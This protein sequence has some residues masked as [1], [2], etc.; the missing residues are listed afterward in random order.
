MIKRNFRKISCLLVIAIFGFYGF[1]QNSF[2]K[3]VGTVSS[4]YGTSIIPMPNLGSLT[5]IGG[6]KNDGTGVQ[7]GLVKTNYNGAIEWQKLFVNGP[8][9]LAQNTVQ[10]SDGGLCVFG[11]VNQTMNSNKALFILKTDSLGNVLWSYRIQASSSDRAV[12]IIS[13]KSGGFLSCSI[14]GYNNGGYPS[15]QLI[16]Y[17]ESGIILWTKKYDATLGVSPKSVIELSNG[18][19]GF[20]SLINAGPPTFFGHTLLT[21]TDAIGNLRWSTMFNGEYQDEPFDLLESTSGEF[22]ITGARYELAKEWDGYYL[23]VDSAGNRISNTFYDANTSSGEYF[24]SMALTADNGI[25]LLGDAG[26]FDA[27]NI[28]LLKINQS[29]QVLWSRNYPFSS[30]Y[31][32]YGF[33]IYTS[34]DQGF[35]FSG[36]VRPQSYFR[37]AAIIKAGKDGVIP[38]FTQDL[39]FTLN[40]TPFNESRI[41]LSQVDNLQITQEVVVFTHP[42]DQITEKLVCE[43]KLPILNFHSAKTT[44]CPYVCVDFKDLSFN[45]PAIWSWEFEGGDPSVS[46]DKNPTV[47]FSTPGNHSV[48]LTASNSFGTVSKVENISLDDFDCPMPEIPN[49]FSPNKD[50]TN[51]LFEFPIFSTE[52]ELFIYNRWGTIVYSGKGLTLSWDGKTQQGIDATEGV[53][54]YRLESKGEM[55]QGFLHLTR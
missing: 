40:T 4:D 54:F 1:S 45:E 39:N 16:R 27:R 47:C 37:D 24:R 3:T 22:L 35:V 15:A 53:Y 38:C 30:N 50:G 28:S 14:S 5:T 25:V 31:T 18:D 32:N 19:F 55:R 12:N 21:R 46:T 2:L 44:N 26:S 17:S 49:V 11:E 43:N 9:A 51:D 13:C 36:D 8:F 10:T 6:G 41:F 7:F 48:K 33:D 42:A 20:I 29:G 52:T 34:E 23:K